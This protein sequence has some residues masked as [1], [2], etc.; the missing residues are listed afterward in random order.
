MSRVDTLGYSLMKML[1]NADGSRVTAHS[2]PVRISGHILL[3]TSIASSH[4]MQL[5]QVHVSHNNYYQSSHELQL[6]LVL[7]MVP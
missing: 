1:D 7:L 2:I 4:G 5:T 3:L 6:Q